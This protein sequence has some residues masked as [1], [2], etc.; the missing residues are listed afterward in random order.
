VGCIDDEV[1]V[2]RVV[3]RGDLPVV[4]ADERFLGA[5]NYAAF[6]AIEA[7]LG[8]AMAGADATRSAS[9]LAEL[10]G[11]SAGAVLQWA[12][13]ALLPPSDPKKGGAS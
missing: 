6:R 2:G 9:A 5:L 3:Q 7:E 4:D 12:S 13:N 10:F 1:G 8:Q 11:L